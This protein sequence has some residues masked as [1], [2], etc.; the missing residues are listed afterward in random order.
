MTVQ[1][2]CWVEVKENVSL[3]LQVDVSLQGLGVRYLSALTPE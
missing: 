1:A 2:W 3:H